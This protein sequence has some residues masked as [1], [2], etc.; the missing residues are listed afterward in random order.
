MFKPKLTAERILNHHDEID[1][2]WKAIAQHA[3]FN[4]RPAL[5]FNNAALEGSANRVGVRFLP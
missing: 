1:P 3:F 2:C 5:E 4:R